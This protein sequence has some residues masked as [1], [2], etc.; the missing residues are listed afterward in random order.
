MLHAQVSP[1]PLLEFGAVA[2]GGKPE[3]Q[4]GVGQ[5]Y[6][7]L[8]VVNPPAV[9]NEGFPGPESRFLMEALM[10]GGHL[11]KDLFS[12]PAFLFGHNAV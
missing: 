4:G 8:L 11:F 12:C 2:A 7:F 9:V 5:V 10:I 1:E 6:H 3:I